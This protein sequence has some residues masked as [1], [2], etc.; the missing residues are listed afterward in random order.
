MRLPRPQPPGAPP[1]HPPRAWV[2]YGL[3]AVRR[4]AADLP[5]DEPSVA[6]TLLLHGRHKAAVAGVSHSHVWGDL[7]VRLGSDAINL[8]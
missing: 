1:A 6:S 4:Q 8:L 3:Q 5:G 2:P 7:G